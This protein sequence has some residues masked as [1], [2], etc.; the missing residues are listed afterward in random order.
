MRPSTKG[1]LGVASTLLADWRLSV[2]FKVRAHRSDDGTYQ[3]EYGKG[4]NKLVATLQCDA[5][6]CWYVVGDGCGDKT[7]LKRDAVDAWG[8]WAAKNYVGKTAAPKAPPVSSGPPKHR[9]GPAVAE[10][11]ELSDNDRA[12]FETLSKR[13]GVLTEWQRSQARMVLRSLCGLKENPSARDNSS[14]SRSSAE[15]EPSPSPGPD[16]EQEA[17]ET[18]APAEDDHQAAN[19]TQSDI[20]GS[21]GT[22]LPGAE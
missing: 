2:A 20:P 7:R 13:H 3:L 17:T 11:D 15:A 1:T 5:A 14:G 8:A 10:E 21:E 6:G 18:E 4:S 22:A 16:P 9:A 12:F 19:G